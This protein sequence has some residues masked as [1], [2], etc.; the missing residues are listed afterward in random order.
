MANSS[1]L[2]RLLILTRATTARSGYKRSVD[3][4]RVRWTY[5]TS[6]TVFARRRRPYGSF[7][8]LIRTLHDIGG[9][10]SAA[11]CAFAYTTLLN[12]DRRI[13]ILVPGSLTDSR[14]A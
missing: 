5:R 7:H 2:G 14:N 13:I 11:D 1:S 3:V 12:Q 8:I 10:F 9:L 6:P 4:L